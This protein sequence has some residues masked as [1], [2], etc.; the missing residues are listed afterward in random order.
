MTDDHSHMTIIVRMT[1]KLHHAT[2][3]RYERGSQ[4]QRAVAMVNKMP[5][6]Y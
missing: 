2:P 3:S 5:G 6:S 1:R 4:W